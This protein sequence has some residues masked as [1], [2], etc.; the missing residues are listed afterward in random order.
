MIGEQGHP[1]HAECMKLRPPQQLDL[2][3]AELQALQQHQ[4]QVRAWGWGF[5]DED[6]SC[7][8]PPVLTHVAAV[9]GTPLNATELQ[10]TLLLRAFLHAALQPL[11]C[12]CIAACPGLT[13]LAFHDTHQELLHGHNCIQTIHGDA[14]SMPHKHAIMLARR[15]A[16]LTGLLAPAGAHQWGGQGA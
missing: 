1:L 4:A 13:G 3:P 11:A 15:M 10:V 2:S 7:S 8:G 9:L 12:A 16:M 5:A 6:L 14:R